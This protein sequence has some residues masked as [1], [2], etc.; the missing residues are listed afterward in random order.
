MNYRK[1]F[2]SDLKSKTRLVVI[3]YLVISDWQ[4][5]IIPNIFMI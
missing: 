5:Q 2:L 4:I 3:Q 1:E